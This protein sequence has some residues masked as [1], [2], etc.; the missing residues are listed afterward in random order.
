MPSPM[1]TRRVFGVLFYLVAILAPVARLPN[2]TRSNPPVRAGTARFLTQQSDRTKNQLVLGISTSQICKC[3]PILHLFLGQI[4]NKCLAYI[5]TVATFS[6]ILVLLELTGKFL[7][8]QPGRGS[9]FQNRAKESLGGWVI[10]LQYSKTA[11]QLI[12]H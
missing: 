7:C 5:R 4:S 6:Q 3:Q 8:L 12:A 11:L 9:P 10:Q 2:R 1:G